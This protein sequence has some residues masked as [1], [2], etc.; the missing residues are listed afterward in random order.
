MAKGK[1]DKANAL[2]NSAVE[3]GIGAIMHDYPIYDE[4]RDFI[5]KHI[6]KRKLN[7]TVIELYNEI[8]NKNWSAQK[9]GQALRD[10]IANYVA[11]SDAFD[12]KAQEIIFRKGLEEKAGS[13]FLKGLF[14]RR[15][16]RGE[17]KFAEKLAAYNRLYEVVSKQG[18]SEEIP[19]VYK[20]VKRMRVLKVIT[21]AIEALRYD[22]LI[23][24]K[25]YEQYS[26]IIK[27]QMEENIPRIHQGLEAYLTPQ[28]EEAMKEAAAVFVVLGII[29]TIFSGLNLTGAVINPLV[30]GSSIG[31][32]LLLVFG[33]I[34][35][36]VRL[37]RNKFKN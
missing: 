20:A 11:S 26:R 27:E 28:R 1:L 15:Q 36:F 4:S 6:D 31:G 14:A 32:I 18:F 29:L 12:A 24:D 19:E 2:I 30:A 23:S 8:K 33:L 17:K 35:F 3:E 25:K 34:L 22:H 7:S 37:K 13:G 21:P 16:L 5:E 9:K 10:A